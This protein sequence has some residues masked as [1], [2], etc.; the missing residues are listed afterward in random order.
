MQLFRLQTVKNGIYTHFF[1]QVRL[2][3]RFKNPTADG[4]SVSYHTRSASPQQSESRNV[5][6]P[7]EAVE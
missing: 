3:M 7:L 2:F 6:V 1:G 4:T 5:Y